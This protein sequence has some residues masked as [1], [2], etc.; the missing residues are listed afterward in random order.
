MSLPE[1]LQKQV[2][3]AKSIIEQHY[4]AGNPEAALGEPGGNSVPETIPAQEDKAATQQKEAAVPTQPARP[5]EDENSE[6]YA[7]RWRSLQGIYHAAVQKNQQLEGRISQ[8]EQLIASMQ[9]A[10]AQEVTPAQDGSGLTTQ[11]LEDYGEDLVGMSRRAAREELRTRD[12]VIAQLQ[13]EI[14]ALRAVVPTVQRVAQQQ[15]TTA[16]ERFFQQLGQLVPDFQ[17]VNVNPKFHEWLLTPD[18]MTGIM[19]QT[20]LE[21]AQRTLDV[22]RVANIF[23]AWK[24]LTGAAQTPAQQA[25]T[26]KPDPASELERQVAPGRVTSGNAPVPQPANT[27]TREDITKF[28]DDVRKGAFRGREQ[29][30][31]SIERDIF[32]AQKEGRIRLAA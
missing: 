29:E 26:P 21:D 30:R 16:E 11:D 28:Y 5:A 31:A 25:R 24:E 1:Q 18:S 19:R 27:Y 23:N 14:A 20:Y 2:E 9:T 6:S 10:Q 22:Q 4:G 3:E 8:L 12:A 17:V 32:L 13:Q 7:Q 15:Q